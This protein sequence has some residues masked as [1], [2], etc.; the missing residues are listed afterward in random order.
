MARHQRQHAV[1]SSDPARTEPTK[2]LRVYRVQ[3]L[4][5]QSPSE[6]VSVDVLKP[7]T[8]DGAVL[9]AKPVLT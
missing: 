9:I 7:A 3:P 6:Q 2:D 1:A 5:H 8:Q 4:R